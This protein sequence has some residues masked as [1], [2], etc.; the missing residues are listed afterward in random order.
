VGLFQDVAIIR[1]ERPTGDGALFNLGRL[2]GEGEG[3][4]PHGCAL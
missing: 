4:N 3:E 1:R 2:S